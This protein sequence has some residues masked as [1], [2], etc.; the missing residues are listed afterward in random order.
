MDGGSA[1]KL[2]N[3][4]FLLAFPSL[5]KTR[6]WDPSG[7][8][9]AFEVDMDAHDIILSKLTFPTD[10]HYPNGEDGFRLLPWDQVH[11]E[12]SSCPF[13]VEQDSIKGRPTT[14]PWSASD[15]TTTDDES[16]TD[17]DDASATDAD[18]DIPV[19]EIPTKATS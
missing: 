5:E 15:Q 9:Y 8:G 3:G 16:N 18:S 4:H 7:A 12:S 11:R 2:S 13:S 14:D 6:N 19:Q 10:S 1:R 17:V